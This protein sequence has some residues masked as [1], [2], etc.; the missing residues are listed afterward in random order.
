MFY[1]SRFNIKKY[2]NIFEYYIVQENIIYQYKVP[3]EDL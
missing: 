3:I 2:V 1:I